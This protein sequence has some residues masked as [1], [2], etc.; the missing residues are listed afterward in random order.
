MA[1]AISTADTS[2]W[3]SGAADAAERPPGL[4]AAAAPLNADH[5]PCPTVTIRANVVMGAGVGSGGG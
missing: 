1:L 3:A 5:R 4:T 2:I